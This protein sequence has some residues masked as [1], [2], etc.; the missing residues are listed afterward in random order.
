MSLDPIARGLAK[1]AAS[2]TALAATG[3]GQGASLIGYRAGAA[4]A[5][6]RTVQDKVRE[7]ASVKDF[8]AIG[9]GV[10]DDTAAIQAAITATLTTSGGTLY[11]PDGIYKLTAKLV[12]PFSIGWRIRGQ[13]RAGTL[14]R[15]ATANTPILSLESNLTHSWEI[16]DVGF[17]WAAAQPATN[18]N[19]I[20]IRMG[21]GTAGQTLF[22][23]QVRRCT[24][25]NGFR[26]IAA[27]AVNSPA[28]WG[29]R[30][31]DCSFGGS[32]TGAA[33]YAVPS[34]A[35]GQPNIAIE[36]C[37]IDAGS[38]AEAPIRVSSGDN[39]TYKNL[40]F[41]NGT[42]PTALI[43]TSTTTALTIIGCKTENYNAGWRR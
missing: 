9:D 20:G 33:F 29:I 28:I 43:D 1:Q 25:A 38:A 34:P 21:T 16:S 7:T 42:A 11:F 6:A 39:V 14:L 8:G 37:L 17:T 13:S 22:N 27:D 3:N 5:V 23:W 32:M 24:F 4:S 30:I 35:I 15:Q 2:T 18:T 26:A 41:L 36:N 19:A 10:A 31:S 40:E 12:V